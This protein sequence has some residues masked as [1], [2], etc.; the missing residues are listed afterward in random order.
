[1]CL[2][3][4]RVALASAY[5]QTVRLDV[6]IQPRSPRNNITHAVTRHSPHRHQTFYIECKSVL[7][8]VVY[9]L[10]IGNHTGADQIQS[11]YISGA[12]W[13]LPGTVNGAVQ[14]S[15]SSHAHLCLWYESSSVA[16]IMQLQTHI[17]LFQDGLRVR[18]GFQDS[19]KTSL[20]V[21]NGELMV[22]K[23]LVQIQALCYPATYTA[24]P[25]VFRQ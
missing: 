15:Y 5:Y 21:R 17:S 24:F 18:S 7:S 11:I 4:Q 14:A 25:Y 19:T 9:R 22:E 2:G 20:N 13:A 8:D 12:S 3:L 6:I 16:Y 23:K 10:L 1:M